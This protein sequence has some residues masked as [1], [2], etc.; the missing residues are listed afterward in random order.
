MRS[1]LR[2]QQVETVKDPATLIVGGLNAP[3]SRFADADAARVFYR[4]VVDRIGMMPGVVDVAVASAAPMQGWGY[5]LPMRVPSSKAGEA[6]ARFGAGF[7][8]VSPSYFQTIGLPIL[9]GRVLQ[10]SDSSTSPPVVV[11]NQAFVSRYFVNQEAIGRH[12]LIDRLIPGLPQV[13]PETA[14]E[15]VGVVANERVGG[16]SEA[17]SA[18]VYAPFEQSPF[19]G[20]TLVLRA[21]RES[22]VTAASLKAAIQE[23][24]P[25]QPLTNV[26]T[27]QQVKA[28]SVAPDRLRTWLIVLFGSI[29]GLLAGIGIYGVI[30]YSVAQRTHEIGV[31]AA[32]GATRG[33][34]VGLVMGRASLLT[35]MGLAAGLGTAIA[36]GRLLQT[37]LF[38]VTPHDVVSLGAAAILLAAVAMIAAWI[39]AR[40][41]AAVDPL[42]ALRVE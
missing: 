31:R 40:R 5:G 30:S 6:P 20:P 8:M 15:I 17:D 21:A 23:I 41:A 32:L 7:K 19:Y 16:L 26:R 3:D 37:F 2:L 28:E 1:F 39:P 11:V 36:S 12:L 34:L 9:K 38:G 13:G 22:A 18:G 42:V 35:G 4:R 14:W 24:D 25:N 27:L 33:R 10:P 29:A